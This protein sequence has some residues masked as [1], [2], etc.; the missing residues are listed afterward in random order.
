MAYL[1]ITA[2]NDA[3]CKGNLL[4]KLRVRLQRRILS[5]AHYVYL[6]CFTSNRDGT[7]R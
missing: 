5:A 4:N 1:L 6:A 2:R 3:Y 7:S